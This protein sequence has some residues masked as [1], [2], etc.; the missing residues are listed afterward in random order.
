MPKK[1]FFL[2]LII[3]I[4]S[5]ISGCA[6]QKKSPKLENVTLKLKWLHQA[7]FAGNYAAKEK[8]IYEKYGL[9]TTLEPFS[10][11]SPTIEAVVSGKA[12]FGITGADELMLA[13]EKGL[14]IKALA[15]IYKT[16]PVCAYSLQN[17]N[18]TKPQD[19]LGKTI[20]I[21]RASDGTEVNIGILYSAMMSRLGINREKINEITIGYDASE[22]LAGKT[23]ISTGYIINEPHQVVEAGQKVNTILMADY[24]VNMYA[25]VLF[26]TEDIIN[27]KPDLVEKFVRAT[28]DGWQFAIE[29]QEETIDMILKYA[30]NSSREH[31]KYMLETSIPLIYTGDSPLGW[32]DA[33]QWEGVQRT[34][35]DQEIL[36]KPIRPENAYT[37]EFLNKIYNI[38]N[39]QKVSVRLSWLHQNQFAGFYAADQMGFYNQEGINVNLHSAGY[40]LSVEDQIL[41]G[42]SSFGVSTAIN[43][44]KKISEGKKLKAIAAIHQQDPTVFISLKEKNMKTL[45]DFKNITLAGSDTGIESV[46]MM[47]TKNNIDFSSVNFIP[48][49]YGIKS[50][51]DP[52]VD[53]LTGV[54]FNELIDAQN[55]NLELNALY[56]KD[57]NI[58][59]YHNIIFATEEFIQ[60]NPE[61]VKKFMKASLEGWK[62]V[63]SHPNESTNFVFEYDMGLNPTHQE[64]MLKDSIRYI[65]PEK[66]TQIGRMTK[67]K[68]QTT[69]D[70]LKAIGEIK[71]EF[72]VDQIFTNEFIQ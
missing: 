37:M 47:L 2:G 35:F 68:W 57:N 11:E 41:A 22:L 23:D 71:N 25:D 69:Y 51:T 54:S 3:T 32:M 9:N 64:K 50:L 30:V 42:E 60:K 13:R 8:G 59:G 29:N 70:D 49:K 18:I 19:F 40:G 15:V 52:A 58:N 67:E 36:K 63:V 39:K 43:F 62:Y 28:L 5:I 33:K 44:L 21:E 17:S 66:N 20:G 12:E 14:P 4:I 65:A 7:Q 61:L 24:G 16:N 27:K 38:K 72:D 31:Q 56:P 26:T 34:L 48:K 1:I 45:Q 10:F 55:N 6:L 53:V 46:K